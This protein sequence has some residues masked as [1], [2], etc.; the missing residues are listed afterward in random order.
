M[1][2]EPSITPYVGQMLDYYPEDDARVAALCVQVHHFDGISRPL[3]DLQIFW[4]D[5]SLD[6]KAKVPPAM[7]ADIEA[8]NLK[9]HWGFQHEFAILQD[10][11]Q[12][13]EEEMG[14]QTNRHVGQI[15]PDYLY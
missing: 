12:L 14:T 11:E 5:G 1:I 7:S 6:F 13:P 9:E 8:P 15:S 2:T 10:G 3:L 4:A